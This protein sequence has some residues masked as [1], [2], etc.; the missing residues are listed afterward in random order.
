M[1]PY[2]ILSAIA[3]A[4][5]E[6]SAASAHATH[7]SCQG[8]G[9]PHQFI[10]TSGDDTIDGTR[11]LGIDSRGALACRPEMK[12]R[13]ALGVAVMALAGLLGT[14]VAARGADDGSDATW[15][16]A[17]PLEPTTL[18]C[19][20]G[21]QVGELIL[22]A[23]PPTSDN[24]PAD[25]LADQVLFL[26][27]H[28]FDVAPSDFT[29]VFQDRDRAQ[30]ALYVGGDVRVLIEVRNAAEAGGSRWVPAVVLDCGPEGVE[31]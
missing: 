29:L 4:L 1:K 15:G 27:N 31:A 24:D 30:F 23:V 17:L 9:V 12:R 10:G 3:M 5:L 19:S 11:R 7:V 20:P 28:G 16:R 8:Q 22:D 14:L 25:A 21:R 26:R 13:V 18:A 2:L 6:L